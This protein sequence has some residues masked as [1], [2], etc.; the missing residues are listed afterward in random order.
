MEKSLLCLKINICE[1]LE[2]C[3][4]EQTYEVVDWMKNLTYEVNCCTLNQLVIKILIDSKELL[5]HDALINLSNKANAKTSSDR[6]TSSNT[7]IQTNNHFPL[8]KL[9]IDLISIQWGSLLLK[10][11][12][13]TN[14]SINYMYKKFNIDTLTLL[15]QNVIYQNGLMNK[16]LIRTLNFSSTLKNLTTE[17]DT[18]NTSHVQRNTQ[19]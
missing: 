16:L 2:S 17:I 1:Y 3:N 13:G 10:E 11:Y 15:Q 4:E 8:L 6:N 9:P 12:I 7:K 18:Q 5:S 19:Y 14:N